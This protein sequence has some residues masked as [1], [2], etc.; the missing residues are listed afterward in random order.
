MNYLLTNK[1]IIQ[2]LKK[3]N[4]KILLLMKKMNYTII[5]DNIKNKNY[6]DQ[7]HKIKYIYNIFICL[8]LFNFY[9]PKIEIMIINML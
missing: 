8:Y 7:N 3:I 6:V 2:Y 4:F 9:Q 1:V 5:F